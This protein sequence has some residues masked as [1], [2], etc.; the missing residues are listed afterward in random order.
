[1]NPDHQEIMDE[2]GLTYFP[3]LR[4]IFHKYHSIT[5]SS[6][7]NMP[8]LSQYG[9]Y[10]IPFPL[11]APFPFLCQLTCVELCF[12][13]YNSFDMSS[14]AQTLHGMANLRCVTLEF[15]NDE[16]GDVD[17]VEWPLS[18]PEPEPHS[19]HVDSLKITL[20][21]YVGDDFVDSLY[22]IL[23]YLTASVV[24]VSLLS[25]GHPDDLLTHAEFP[26]GS[27]MRLR[28]RLPCSLGYVLEEL[29]ANCP[30]VCSVRFEMTPF[31][32]ETYILPKWSHSTSLRHLR[33][34]DCVKLDETHIETLARD[35]LSREDFRS[36]E[37]IACHKIS[38]EF[39]MNLQD[40]LGE[41]LIWSL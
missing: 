38:E 28:T 16:D 27:T 2:F 39:L 25:Y 7:W 40:E 6:Q 30:I 33:F 37:V 35:V 18:T 5:K 22:G 8:L 31:D 29:L 17:V 10:C 24:D 12:E 19:F 13:D 26:Y 11:G 23:T 36:L 41:R 3:R 1:M 14:L 21:D 32:R 34:H 4:Q 9:G 20:R 15:G